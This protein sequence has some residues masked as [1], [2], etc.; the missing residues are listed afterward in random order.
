MPLQLTGSYQLAAP[1]ERVFAAL[2]DPDVLQR[3]IE[4]AERLVRTADDDYDVH[5]KI[6]VGPLK[7][8]YVGKV[9]LTNRQPPERFTLELDG[10]GG[11]GFVR[12]AA[13]IRLDAREAGTEAI[14]EAEGQVG[15]LLAAVGSRL[16]GAAGRTLM[17]RFFERLSAE[18]QR[19]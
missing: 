10:K 4:G 13:R 11:P 8:S 14:C 15:G 6:G 3:C 12:G 18:L 2:V 5:L 9:R 16:I 17:D 19:A 1:R 7:G